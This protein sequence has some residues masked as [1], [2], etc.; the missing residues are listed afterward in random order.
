MPKNNKVYQTAIAYCVSLP[1]SKALGL[2]YERAEGTQQIFSVN[3]REELV[4]NAQ[5]DVLHGGIMTALIDVAGGVAVA[6]HLDDFESLVTLDL[7]IDYLKAAQVG[8]KVY[9]QAECYRLAGQVAFVRTSCFHLDVNAPIAFG[10][11]T[12][13]RTPLSKEIKEKLQ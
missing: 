13:M 12:Y 3:W 4:G 9:A 11:A 7:R 10:M 1:Y 2:H 8:Q 5:T 6:A